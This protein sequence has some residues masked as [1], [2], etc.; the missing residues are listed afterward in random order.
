MIGLLDLDNF[1]S[2]KWKFPNLALMKISAYYK[3]LGYET[4]LYHHD[5]YY[6]K[7]FV[8]R[9][10]DFTEDIDFIINAKEIYYGGVGY[11]VE[12]DKFL[13]DEIE[14]IYPDY[15]LYGV[16]DT[17]YGF[18]SRGCPRNCSFCNVTQHQ[19]NKSRKVAKLSEFW[20]GQ[21]KIV[22]LDPNITLCRDK[23]DIL[24]ELIESKATV[25]FSQGLDIRSLTPKFISYLNKLRFATI[26]LAWDNYEFK[27]YAKLKH[28]RP[29][30]NGGRRKY[31]V[32]V[33]VNF[34]TTIEQDL[35][36]IHKLKELDYWPYVMIFDKPNSNILN[37]KMQRW[38]NNRMIWEQGMTFDDYIKSFKTIPQEYY[39]HLGGQ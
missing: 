16:T 23:F 15:E 4:E 9:V 28:A 11:G 29:L 33:L 14:H 22:L 35:E 30:L 7:V 26:H 12:N 37:R 32:Y 20:R 8:S 31:I 38:V 13:D 25:D 27:T 2:G 19:G 17:A 21:K 39:N 36:R 5:R 1:R 24:D 6:E 10:F 3:S 18:M 34:N